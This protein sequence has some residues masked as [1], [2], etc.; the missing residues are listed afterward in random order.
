[1]GTGTDVAIESA[2]ITLL[3]GELSGTVKARSLAG[4]V[5]RRPPLSVGLMMKTPMSRAAAAA[6]AGQLS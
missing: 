3:K 1:M 6:T 2:G 5:C 4:G